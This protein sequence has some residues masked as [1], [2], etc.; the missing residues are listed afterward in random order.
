MRDRSR[1]WSRYEDVAK[2]AKERGIPIYTFCFASSDPDIVDELTAVS[3]TTQGTSYIC[4]GPLQMMNNV[5]EV[6]MKY[7]DEY[8]GEQ[9]CFA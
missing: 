1:R 8:S 3:T 5:L 2:E 4:K 9:I 6:A 7:K